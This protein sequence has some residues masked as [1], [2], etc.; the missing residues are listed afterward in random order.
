MPRISAATVAEHRAAQERALLDAAHELLQETSEAPTMAEVAER[1]GLS[2][3]SVYQYFGSRQD[4]LQALVRDIFP[5]WTERV[6]GAMANAPT[7]ADRILAYALANVDLVAEGAHAVGS[8]LA[9]L[10]PGAELDEQATRMHRQLQEPLVETLTELGV[11]DPASLA[12]MINSVVYAGTRM[13]ESGQTL[14]QVHSH[15]KTLLGPFVAE[16]QMPR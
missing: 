10:A 4:L 11:A 7:K 5:R 13:L 2:R 8:A 16:R 3:P 12:E 1:A 15:L 6:T 9:A 14:E